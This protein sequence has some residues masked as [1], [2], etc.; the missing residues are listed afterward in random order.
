MDWEY[1]MG[2]YLVIDWSMIMAHTEKL[3]WNFGSYNIIDDM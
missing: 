2:K 3:K 1:Y